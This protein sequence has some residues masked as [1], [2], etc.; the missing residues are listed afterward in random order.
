MAYHVGQRDA[1]QKKHK[2]II[3]TIMEHNPFVIL[4]KKLS[5]LVLH[6]L[7]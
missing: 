3:M 5:L 4:G 2:G 7:I 6:L 1:D